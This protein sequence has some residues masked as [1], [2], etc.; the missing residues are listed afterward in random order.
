MALFANRDEKNEERNVPRR[1]VR[2]GQQ[3]STG[4][5]GEGRTQRQRWDHLESRTSARPSLVGSGAS[6]FSGM[7][8]NPGWPGAGGP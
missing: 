5:S 3:G 7:T 6:H 2:F 4:C 1:G 8:E